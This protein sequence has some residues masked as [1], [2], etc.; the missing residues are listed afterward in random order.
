MINITKE[1]LSKTI[2]RLF[3]LFLF[4]LPW[5]TMW[6]WHVGLLNADKWEYGTFILYGTELLLW[7]IIV[8]QLG[9]WIKSKRIGLMDLKLS[10]S[11]SKIVIGVWL[12]VIWSGLSIFWSPD[13]QLAFYWWIKLLEVVALFFIIINLKVDFKKIGWAFLAS[14]VIQSFLAMG[15]FWSQQV[16][17]NKW[18]GMAE[19]L[20]YDIGAIVISYFDG[21]DYYR[22]IRAYGSLAHPN[23]LGGFLVVCFFLGLYLHLNYQ[24]S[25]KKIISSLSLLVIF[26]GM[27]FSFSRGAWLAWLVLYL[28]LIVMFLVYKKV[29]RV[30]LIKLGVY[31]ALLFAVLSVIYQ[32]LVVSRFSGSDELEIRSIQD[33]LRSMREAKQ[34]ISENFVFGTGLGNYTYNLYLRDQSLRQWDYQPVHNIFLLALSETGIVGFIGFLLIFGY[35]IF[36]LYPLRFPLFPYFAVTC[37]GG[38]TPPISSI[39]KT[40][41]EKLSFSS[42]KV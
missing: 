30:N 22:W 5:Q 40:S 21:I 12:L 8:L 16:I 27:F 28:F 3:Y 2:E 24:P 18:L 7:L 17:G 41:K 23:V 38:N 39:C 9:V 14:G 25:L 32:P 34:M 15:Q 33:R 10:S 26:V 4:L 36:K 35:P 31:L 37:K 42:S 13:K 20:P 1:Y 11:K 6:I 19:H 29:G